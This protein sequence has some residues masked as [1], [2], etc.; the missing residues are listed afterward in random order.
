[1]TALE[2]DLLALVKLADPAK[3]RAGFTTLRTKHGAKAVADKLA[4]I[5]GDDGAAEVVAWM[6]S[7]PAAPS[8]PSEPSVVPSGILKSA[9]WNRFP[10]VEFVAPEIEKR[11]DDGSR[12]RLIG[13]LFL[14]GKKVEWIAKGRQWSTVHNATERLTKEGKPNRYFQN[15]QSGQKVTISIA[16]LAGRNESN[17]V[18]LV[19]P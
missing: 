13:Q 5:F 3:A 1:M 15:I 14:N 9:K 18:E 8:A 7:K 17:R 19:W 10:R 11:K 6:K 12:K 4:Q 2:Q 16:D